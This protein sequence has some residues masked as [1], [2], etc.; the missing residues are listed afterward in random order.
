MKSYIYF[1][2]LAATLFPFIARA[3]SAKVA[4]DG[5]SLAGD[6]RGDSICVVKPSACAISLKKER[7]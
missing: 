1:A 7:A 5:N 4:A 6:W 3:Q 2:L